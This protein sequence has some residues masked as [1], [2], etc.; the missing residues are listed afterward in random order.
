M[1]QSSST[2]CIGVCLNM[3]QSSFAC[4]IGVCLNMLQSS[5]ACCIGVCLNMLQSS[6]TCC[7][8]VCLNMLQSSS[9]CCIGV[10]LNRQPPASPAVV[11]GRCSTD[12]LC[13]QSPHLLSFATVQLHVTQLCLFV[14]DTSCIPQWPKLTCY[15]QRPR[16]CSTANGRCAFPRCCDMHTHVQRRTPLHAHVHTQVW[17]FD[18]GKIIQPGNH[19]CLSVSNT[20]SGPQDAPALVLLPCAPDGDPSAVNQSWELRAT[21]QIAISGRP[22][23]KTPAGP[24]S[25]PAGC[26]IDVPGWVAPPPFV[27][28]DVVAVI[29]LVTR[30]HQL[31]F[32]SANVI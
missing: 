18:E 1:L 30:W 14:Q 24:C 17:H 22:E 11:G 6:S 28:S 20:S 4:C 15:R 26:C 10:C 21:G 3:L 16:A 19:L 29:A 5:S 23:I 27:N 31:V 7:I 13:A 8:G 25:G 9:A 32:S 2:C 12:C